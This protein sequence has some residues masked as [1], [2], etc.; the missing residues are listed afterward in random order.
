MKL[1]DRY[2][3]REY[4][5]ATAYCLTAFSILY[6]VIDMF[7]RLPDFL[8]AGISLRRILL[9]YGNYLMA[10]NGP[11]SFFTLMLPISMLLGLL[12]ALYGLSRHNELTAMRACGVS[13]YRLM[14]PFLGAGCIAV[15]ICLFIQ[16]K[17]APPASLR[18]EAMQRVLRGATE[19]MPLLEQHP[20]YHSQSRRRWMIGALDPRQPHILHDVRV[21]IEREDRSR[22][23]ELNAERAEWL[24][25]NWWFFG[26]SKR[27]FDEQERPLGPKSPPSAIPLEKPAFTESPSDI[28]RGMRSW[29]LFS[30]WEMW[31]FISSHPDLSPEDRAR[32]SVDLHIRLAM[33]WVCLVVTFLGFPGGV[34]TQRQGALTGILTAIFFLFVFYTLLQSG[35]YMAKRLLIPPWIGAWLPNIIFCTMGLRMISRMK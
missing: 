14:L 32:R 31:R 26:A 30:A 3:L 16:E 10:I 2:L 1:I 13:L 11:T 4:L 8:A 7:E 33:P 9:F 25:G 12:Y 28:L 27:A 6:L 5:G 29:E 18:V 21:A 24:D 22:A 23:M 19:E 34:H 15:A 17:I 35:N 20:F